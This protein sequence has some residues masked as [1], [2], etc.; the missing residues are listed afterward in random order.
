MKFALIICT[1]ERAT[2]LLRL[3]NSVKRQEVYPDEILIIDGSLSH[4]TKKAL[5]EYSISNLDYYYVQTKYRGLT[6]QRNFG[7]SKLSSGLD[8]AF[9]LDDDVVLEP[10]Y[11][12]NILNT[13]RKHPEALGV[14]GYI[15]DNKINWHKVEN[16]TVLNDEFEYDGWKRKLGSRNFLRK[17]LNLL[18]DC[19]PGIMPEFSNGFSIS[20]LPPSGKTYPVEFFM[21]GVSSFK[22]KILNEV[23]FSGYF[24]GYGLYEDM[25][26]CLR[27]S[28]LG[29]LYV[30]T[31]ARLYHYHD[32]DGRPNQFRYGTMVS[33]NGKYVWR[34]KY[35][36]PR[37]KAKIKFYKIS[38]LLTL[39]RL[40][41][42]LTTSKRKEAFTEALGRFYGIITSTK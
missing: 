4:N 12:E 39:V 18:S 1:F 33:R 13:Y 8:I 11:F 20:F 19:A 28:K 23:Q 22:T 41:N 10:H 5:K 34:V 32:P 6:K 26:Y 16:T 25:D 31:S 3:L 42:A 30:N 24:E 37:F 27:V 35:P 40:G 17:K 2:A 29:Q 15:I 7:I 9:F 14:G 36:N 38:L 21:G